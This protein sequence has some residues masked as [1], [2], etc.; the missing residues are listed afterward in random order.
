MQAALGL[1]QLER[2]EAFYAH[3][4]ALYHAYLDQLVDL[5]DALQTQ[6]IPP[7]VRSSYWVFPVVLKDHLDCDARGFVGRLREAG[8]EARY[9]FRPLDRQ[10]CLNPSVLPCSDV[11]LRLWE[12]GVYLP[13]GNGITREEVDASAR[14]V[15]RLVRELGA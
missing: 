8:V 1:S 10:P 14:V 3:R 7:D 6:C 5:A 13:L 15:R 4:Q 9:F 11:G 2:A 12:R